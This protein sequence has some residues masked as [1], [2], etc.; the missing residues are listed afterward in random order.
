MLVRFESGLMKEPAKASRIISLRDIFAKWGRRSRTER[1]LLLEAFMLL[2]AARLFVLALPFR[3]LA[4]SLGRHM[5]EDQA[6]VSP[7][8]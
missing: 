3:W 4:R 2:A 5:Q 8:T 7:P 6:P 1:V